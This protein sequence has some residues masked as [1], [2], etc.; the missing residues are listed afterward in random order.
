MGVPDQIRRG[1]LIVIILNLIQARTHP[2][3]LS[4]RTEDAGERRQ[5]RHGNQGA[6][7]PVRICHRSPHV[8]PEYVACEHD[9]KKLL[10]GG[11]WQDGSMQVRPY[12]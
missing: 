1:N 12:L 8:G 11:K 5:G 4:K 2:V 9:I 3:A 6:A 7:A 10:L